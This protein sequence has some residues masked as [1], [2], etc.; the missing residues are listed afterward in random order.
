MVISSIS[1][2]I[3][4]YIYS[5]PKNILRRFRFREF[6]VMFG[7]AIHMQTNLNHELYEPQI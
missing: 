7:L 4:D 5:D 2:V 1:V 6:R 3:G